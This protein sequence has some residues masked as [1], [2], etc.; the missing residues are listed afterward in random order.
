MPQNLRLHQSMMNSFSAPL[1]VE[2]KINQWTDFTIH[3][4]QQSTFSPHVCNFLPCIDFTV[5]VGSEHETSTTTQN[6]EYL[7][8]YTYRPTYV[9]FTR[10]FGDAPLRIESAYTSMNVNERCVRWH[11]SCRFAANVKIDISLRNDGLTAS[12]THRHTCIFRIQK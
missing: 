12:H 8:N 3:N 5:G 1:F 2:C 9:S 7:F 4:H 10:T 6:E 11:V